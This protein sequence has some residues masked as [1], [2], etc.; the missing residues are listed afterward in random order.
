VNSA[1]FMARAAQRLSCSVNLRT[2]YAYDFI[3]QEVNGCADCAG[4]DSSGRTDMDAGL[5][6]AP[7]ALEG[8]RLVQTEGK[9]Q[10]CW[11]CPGCVAGAEVREEAGAL[12]ATD[13]A[14]SIAADPICHS[15]RRAGRLVA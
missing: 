4:C 10:L 5:V 6:A 13:L 15:C 3:G 14:V 11:P 9:I 2:G 1:Y 7:G 8:T 12:E